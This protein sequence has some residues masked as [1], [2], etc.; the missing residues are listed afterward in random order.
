M[1]YEKQ[2][3]Q[4]AQSVAKYISYI[5]VDVTWEQLL[6]CSLHNPEFD[7][8]GSET[9]VLKEQKILS[10][11]LFVFCASTPTKWC[12]HQLDGH[13]QTNGKEII[14]IHP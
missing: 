6:T 10:M 8:F 11:Y 2:L 12:K 1:Y 4:T 13:A 9:L 7:D 5:M 3:E 14:S